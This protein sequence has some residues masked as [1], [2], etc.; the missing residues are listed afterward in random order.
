MPV[1]IETQDP[2]GTANQFRDPDSGEEENTYYQELMPGNIFYGNTNEK[3]HI[4]SSNR[5]G[6]TFESFVER[7]LRAVGASTGMPYEIVAKDF[8]KTNY[9]S[10]RAALLEAWRV[11]RFYQKWLVDLYCQ[12]VWEMVL[13]EAFLRGYLN[14]S[15]DVND[16]YANLPALT[17]ARWIP[18]KRGHVD[19]VKEMNANIKGLDNDVLTLADIV[20]DDGGDW[21][22]V[23]EQRA[24]EKEKKQEIMP[25]VNDDT[26]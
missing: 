12:P 17:R 1:W 10:A 18:P 3:P 19:P 7:V 21:E 24:R 25:A 8:S 23:L 15:M 5:P 16:F 22:T 6:N 20:A 9:S 4:L 11:F 14:I 13:E 26:E 2:T